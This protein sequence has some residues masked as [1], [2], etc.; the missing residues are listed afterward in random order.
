MKTIPTLILSLLFIFTL[1]SA[2]C[3]PIS[4]TDIEVHVR[5]YNELKSF[6]KKVLKT[7]KIMAVIKHIESR[8][9]YFKRGGS[10]EI[11]AYQFMP[12][13]WLKLCNRY[14]KHYL[15]PTKKNQDFIAYNYI[16]DLVD[17]KFNVSQ[18]GSVWNSGYPNCTKIGFTKTGIPFNVPAYRAGFVHLYKTI[19]V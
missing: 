5:L 10:G 11:G 2:Y 13:T 12:K 3:P 15:K 4:R 17:K 14:A 1:T 19:H 8:D 9:N 7:K 16:M 6:E 18:I